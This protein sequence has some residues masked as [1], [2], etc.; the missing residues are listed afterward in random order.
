[1][2]TAHRDSSEYDHLAHRPALAQQ[3][4]AMV[5]VRELELTAQQTIHRQLAL[6]VEIDIARNIARGNASADVTALHRA[7]LRNQIYCGQRKH[8]RRR[9]QPRGDCRS[10]AARDPVGELECADRPR[11]F[12][13]ERDTAGRGFAYFVLALGA[14]GVEVLRRG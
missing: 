13:R 10:A 12:E 9:W 1:M 5:D 4:K 8:C 3:V 6:A 14:P 11:K 7:L 2:T